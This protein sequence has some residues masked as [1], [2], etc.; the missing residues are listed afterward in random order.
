MT[1]AA[2]AALLEDLGKGQK[3]ALGVGGF[4]AGALLTGWIVKLLGVA[5][6]P[7]KKVPAVPMVVTRVLGGVVVAWLAMLLTFGTGWGP[8]GGDGGGPG[9]DGTSN[10]AKDNPKETAKDHK[11]TSNKD[12]TTPSRHETLRIEALGDETLRAIEKDSFDP[13]RCFRIRKGEK[14]ELLTLDQ[15]KKE[16]NPGGDRLAIRR[17]ELVLYLDSGGRTSP[18]V[19]KLTDWIERL[20][21]PKNGEKVRVDF[22]E[23][24]EKAP[25]N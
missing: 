8:W 4:V 17:I 2:L 18:R 6:A 13:D 1:A 3:V 12:Q 23:P 20:Q 11:D 14:T 5:L 16:I 22:I 10:G 7:G 24:G 25:L 21:P 19:R 15:L 9:R